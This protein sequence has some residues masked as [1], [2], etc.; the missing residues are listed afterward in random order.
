MRVIPSGKGFVAFVIAVGVLAAQGRPASAKLLELTLKVHG[1]GFAGIYGTESYD[2]LSTH[3]DLAEVAG[4]DFFKERRG[5]TFGFTLG[6]EVLFVDLVYEFYQFAD[7]DGLGST[8]NNLLVGFDWDFR[9]GERWVITPYILAGIGLATQ[10]N[11]WLKKKY[12]QISNEDLDSKIVQVRLGL[13]FERMLGRFFRLGFEAG[14]GYHYSMQTVKAANDLDGHSHGFH[15]MGNLY[16]AFVWNVFGKKEEPRGPHMEP[17]RTT[18]PPLP[19]PTQ[20]APDETP[21]A[22]EGGNVDPASPSQGPPVAEP[23]VAE[24]PPAEPP[25]ELPAESEDTEGQGTP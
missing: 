7:L 6:V 2:P 20:N 24:P 23:P 22:P 10:N 18:T 16:V 3:P 13:T 19:G 14:I 15:V 8:L 11:A 25:R 4:K 9:A 1:G 21:A 12:P 17:D 5:G